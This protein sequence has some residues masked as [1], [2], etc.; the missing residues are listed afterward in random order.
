MIASEQLPDLRAPN[1]GNR[2]APRQD[3][4]GPTMEA[5]QGARRSEI[6]IVGLHR[7]MEELVKAQDHLN[8]AGD[9]ASDAVSKAIAAII[10]KVRG[11]QREVSEIIHTASCRK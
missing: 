7:A 3:Q 2:Q 9:H 6:V 8:S 5:G 10:Q 1:N 11:L 4:P